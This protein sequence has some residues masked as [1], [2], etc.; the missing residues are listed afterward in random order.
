M[1]LGLGLLGFFSLFLWVVFVKFKWLE[2]SITWGIVSFYVLLH[3]FLIFVIG[4]RFMT[5][6]SHDARVVQHTIQLVPRLTE[7]TM[8]TKVL[9]EQNVPVKK[10]TP[11]FE[12]DKTIYAAKVAQ[13]EAQL[14]AAKQN[15][16]VLGA[17]VNVSQQNVAKAESELIYAKYQQQ[18]STGLASQK[19]G[20]QEE[21]Q[22]SIAQLQVAEASVKQTKA[23]LERS[24]LKYDSQINGTNT[25]VAQVEAELEAAR[26]FLEN[27][28]L[29]AP[30]DGMIVN[31]QVRP[32]TIAGDLRIG[33]IASFICT[34]DRYILCPLSQETMKYV[35]VGQPT[36]I[37]LD[38]YPGQIFPGKVSEIWKINGD[39]QY[40]P[41]GFLPKFLL[42][43]PD[44]P[45]VRFALKVNFDA[46]DQ[47]IFP[48]GAQG[49]VAV[50][51]TGGAWAAL[52]KISIRTHSWG[53]WLYPLPF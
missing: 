8:V 5:P 49:G 44:L 17:D 39:G 53:N 21:A 9:V 46:K 12:F 52:R 45:Q 14:A 47:T 32:G 18:L 40:S 15:V 41:S 28:T 3:L 1:A 23:E 48:I 51:T 29:V 13:L 11:L 7:P 30:E 19:A 31:L 33:A 6:Y 50:Y 36:E 43:P 38:M 22:K 2:F 34:A 27:T 37:M 42:L 35:R 4:L 26:Y 20:P 25:T 24:Q 10:G 16:L